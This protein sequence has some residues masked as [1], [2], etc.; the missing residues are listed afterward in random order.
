[1]A[2]QLCFP[3]W[4]FSLGVMITTE[5]TEM[6]GRGITVRTAGLPRERRVA[7]VGDDHLRSPAFTGAG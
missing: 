1:M 7:P 3:F 2:E 5:T 6:D 4:F